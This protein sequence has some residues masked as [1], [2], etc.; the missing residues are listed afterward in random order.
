MTP[1]E[2]NQCAS[3]VAEKTKND[4]ESEL[5]YS[6]VNA[7]WQRVETLKSF[8]DMIGKPKETK[9]M[10]ADEMLANVMGIHSEL[11]GTTEGR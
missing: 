11:D 2:L 6:Y 5:F 9:V 4:Q 7:Y 3:V 8:D 1:L 10:S